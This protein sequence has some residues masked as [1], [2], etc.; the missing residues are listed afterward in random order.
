MA[1]YYLQMRIA[2]FVINDKFRKKRK[3][4]SSF[5]VCECIICFVLLFNGICQRHKSAQHSKSTCNCLATRAA[6]TSTFSFSALFIACCAATARERM[7]AGEMY[8][9]A[10]R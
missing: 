2:Y 1:V 5:F 8:G 3:L 4:L 9:Y 7:R 6:V 10:D